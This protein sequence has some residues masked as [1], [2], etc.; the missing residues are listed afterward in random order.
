MTKPSIKNVPEFYRPYIERLKSE[1]VLSA[2][3]EDFTGIKTLFN[4]LTSDQLNFAYSD[5]KWTLKQMLLH[6]CDAERILSYRA[7]RFSRSDRLE[8][9][10]FDQNL[11][12]QTPGLK[13][14][15]KKSLIDEFVLI[16][17]CT[18]MLFNTMSSEEIHKEGISNGY[19]MSAQNIGFVISGHAL[20]HVEIAKTRYLASPKFPK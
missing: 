9:A 20:H 5:D 14:R 3:K 2:L 19:L 13:T 15:S 8:L 4:G 10:G 18:E 17:K 16:R 7:L 6:I 11:Y 1:T 12:V